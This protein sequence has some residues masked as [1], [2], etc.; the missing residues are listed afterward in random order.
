MPQPSPPN[1]NQPTPQSAA[2]HRPEAGIGNARL[3]NYAASDPALFQA[4][5]L[6]SRIFRASNFSAPA[7]VWCHARGFFLIP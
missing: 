7:R 5:L 2:S 4:L 6:T 3:H 1:R